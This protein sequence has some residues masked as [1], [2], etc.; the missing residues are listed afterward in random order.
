MEQWNL[1]TSLIQ[2]HGKPRGTYEGIS[3][4]FA[5]IE[6]SRMQKVLGS[7]SIEIGKRFAVWSRK[8]EVA[9]HLSLGTPVHYIPTKYLQLGS[10]P[11][12]YH[13]PDYPITYPSH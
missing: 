8:V 12:N 10:M 13:Y 11:K 2:K 1:A 9:W 5:F 7:D 6:K 3:G 4:S